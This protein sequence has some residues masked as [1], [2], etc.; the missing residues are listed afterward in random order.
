VGVT[1]SGRKSKPELFVG[2]PGGGEYSKALY[3]Q[4]RANKNKIEGGAGKQEDSP[5]LRLGTIYVEREAPG[6]SYQAKKV[7]CD[8]S[9]A[10]SSLEIAQTPPFHKEESQA[11]EKA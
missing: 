11:R 2:T 7:Q 9:I 4:K 8:G 1:G 10:I 3:S 5:H 6:T